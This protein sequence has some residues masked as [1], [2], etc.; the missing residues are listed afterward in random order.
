VWPDIL[1]CVHFSSPVAFSL[2]LG[3]E[4]FLNGAS[5]F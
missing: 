1:Q 3:F 2:N 4:N 5:N